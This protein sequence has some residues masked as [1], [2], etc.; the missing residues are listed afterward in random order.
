[1]TSLV[2][3]SSG[4]LGGCLVE[5]LRQRGESLRLFDLEP[6]EYE[7]GDAEFVRGDASDEAVLVEAAEG[8]DVVYHLAAAQ[9]MKPQFASWTESDI[10]DRNLAAARNALTA[11]ERQS[12]R[13]VVFTSSSGIYGVP[14]SVPCKEDHPTVPL[15]E[16]G[17][18]KLLAE[19]FYREAADRGQDVTVL[20]PM[21]LFGPRMS[22]IFVMLFEWIR[23]G[24]PVFML[25]SGQNRVQA[26]SA[27]DVADACIRASERPSASGGF[28]N[29]ASDPQSVPTVREE[30]EALVAHAGTGSRI[31][32]IPAVALRSVAKTLNLVGL[33]P[34][35]PEHY[36]LADQNFVLDIAAA[37]DALDW[38]P[39]YDNK[40]M[41]IDAYDSY[42]TAGEA[43]RP[44][45]HPALRMLDAFTSLIPRR[46]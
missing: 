6:P 37:R 3:G 27:F 34:I 1:M 10:F 7:V 30:V 35:V 31:V 9:R 33:S 46:R 32:P 16:Y 29:I 17:R 42:L 39:Q 36:I 19:K 44:A 23:R 4:L 41:M 45:P 20:R 15:G 2:T 11:A 18:S 43:F 28:Y 5:R 21:S 24:Q 14:R 8:C 12:V 22:G 40:S 25:G 26:S 38:E 13:K